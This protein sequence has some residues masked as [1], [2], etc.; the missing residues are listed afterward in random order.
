MCEGHIE[1]RLKGQRDTDRQPE[2]SDGDTATVSAGKVR[3]SSVSGDITTIKSV[4]YILFRFADF[5]KYN[6]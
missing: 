4:P 1:S 5:S 6:T 3:G 2:Q